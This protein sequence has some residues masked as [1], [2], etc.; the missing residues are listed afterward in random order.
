M[1]RINQ[2]EIDTE[3]MI[4]KIQPNIFRKNVFLGFSNQEKTITLPNCSLTKDRMGT[5]VK[6]YTGAE[7]A[8]SNKSVVDMIKL[9][10]YP[11]SFFVDLKGKKVLDVATGGGQFVIDL[12]KLGINILGLD[13]A[14]HQN[15]KKYPKNFIVADA[16]DTKLPEKS[17]DRVFSA[18]SIFSMGKESFDFEIKVLT[19]IKRILKD[20]GKIRF[21]CVVPD[22]IEKIA[23][24]VGG[25][26]V[27]KKE[28]FADSLDRGW[29]ELVKNK[30]SL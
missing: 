30:K 9:G 6:T 3:Y 13:I 4:K 23:L 2:N 26:K 10:T 20:D 25:L 11:L 1:G 16:A 5:M 15:F 24:Q 8:Q 29:I 12:K 14:P 28:S 18:W 17:F 7:Y 19:E 27:T 22:E 21:G